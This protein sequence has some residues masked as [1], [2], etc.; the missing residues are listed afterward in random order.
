M[1]HT[2]RQ[3]A[4]TARGFTLIELLIVIT[5]IAI[6]AAILLPALQSAKNSAQIAGCSNN[7]KQLMVCAL[8][9]AGDTKYITPAKSGGGQNDSLWERL[10]LK[11]TPHADLDVG[12]SGVPSCRGQSKFTGIKLFQCPAD[13]LPR[14]ESAAGGLPV[15]TYAMNHS[16]GASGDEG[17][18]GNG[19]GG[20]SM[21]NDS[22]SGKGY[23]ASMKLVSVPVPSRMIY[24]VEYAPLDTYYRSDRTGYFSAW[25]SSISCPAQQSEAWGG[26]ED[27]SGQEGLEI[28]TTLHRLQWNYA[29]ADG[30]VKIMYPRATIRK[31]HKLSKWNSQH[32]WSMQLD[33]DDN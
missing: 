2:Y 18:V 21:V 7:M 6:L 11:Y 17:K 8:M 28:A 3:S 16:P 23:F 26:D 31:S 33:D 30:H 4:C 20:H 13:K 19:I 29:F 22:F 27:G 10:L 15:R 5:I 14:N 9:Y 32:L 12:I 24:L 25:W 1:T